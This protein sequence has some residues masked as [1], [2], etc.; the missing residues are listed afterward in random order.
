MFVFVMTL[1]VM[2][3]TRA[4]PCGAGG[5]PNDKPPDLGTENARNYA[6]AYYW[7]MYGAKRIEL[8][9]KAHAH[10]ASYGGPQTVTLE[11]RNTDE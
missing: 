2:C 9:T 8:S 5:H 10:R 4:A 6:T 1:L 11:R 7:D 3:N